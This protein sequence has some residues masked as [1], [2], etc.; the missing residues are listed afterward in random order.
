MY[1]SPFYIT[2]PVWNNAFDFSVRSNKSI[3]VPQIID[4]TINDLEIWNEIAFEV[5]E[6]SK[7]KSFKWLKNF[8]RTEWNWIPVIIVDNH[9]HVFYFWFEALKKWIIKDG[10]NLIHID[11]HSDIKDSWKELPLYCDFKEIFEFTNFSLNVWDYIKP[12]ISSWIIKDYIKISGEWELKNY[13]ENL[14]KTR[15]VIPTG[16][17]ESQFEAKTDPFPLSGI[18][19][20][21]WNIQDDKKWNYILNLDIDFFSP[22]LDYIDYNLKKEAILDIASRA[23]LITIATSPYF[24]DQNRAIEIIRALF[25]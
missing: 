21:K 4:W 23:K 16:M 9:N 6:N 19:M 20:T 2:D 14:P 13:K 25:N 18:G 12:A 22:N 10:T 3:Y 7:I 8:I 11:E 1:S 24:V 15:N 5:V 17:E